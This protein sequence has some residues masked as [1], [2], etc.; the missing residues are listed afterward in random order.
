LNEPEAV[1]LGTGDSPEAI[2]ERVKNVQGKRVLLVVPKDCPGLDSLVDLRLLGRQVIVL[3]KEVALVTRDREL[4]ELARSLG[5]RTFSSVEKGQEAKWKGSKP[6]AHHFSTMSPR[7]GPSSK[8]IP[9]PFGTETLRLG[10]TILFSFLFVT[11]L[12]LLGLILIVFVPTATVILEPVTYPVSTTITIQANPDL[13]GLDF[14]NLRLPARVVEIEVVGSDQIA[15]TASRDEPDTRATGEVVFTNKRSQATTVI[16]GTIVTTSAGTTI[17]FHTT[18]EVTLP[19]QVGGRGRA[20]IEAIEPGPSGNVSA[21]SVNRVEGPT[22]RQVNVINV[23]P[24][25]GGEM[26][27]VTYVTN[28]DKEQ[29]RESLLQRLKQEGYDSLV[30]ELGEEEFLPLE[31]S[32]AFVLSETYDKFPGEA[33]DSLG[34][35]MRTLIRGTVVDREGA[36]LLGL[37]MLQLEVREGFQLLSEETKFQ[38]GEISEADYDGT[39]AF[40]MRAEGVTWMEIDEADI[41]EA[42]VGKPVAQAEEDLARQLR[43]GEEPSVEVSPE[44][45]ERV[46]WLPFRISV[47]VLSAGTR[48]D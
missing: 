41:R 19:P 15:T 8:A 17:R 18:E 31:S 47:H 9:A 34:L 33:A 6:G 24:T 22:D 38:T 29:L 11:M 13:E 27:Q 48:I 25:E 39:L 4:K 23:A 1:Y 16:S 3:D 45:W 5:F 46:P 7:Y 32:V 21:Y 26:S 2:R 30:A 36:E 28:A 43:L 12:A 14:V 37:R 40:E 35:H 44:W 20:P 10:E 42:I